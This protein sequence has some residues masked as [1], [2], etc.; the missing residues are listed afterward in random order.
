MLGGYEIERIMP[1]LDFL[2]VMSYDYHGSWDRKTGHNSP[3]YA[4]SDESVDDRRLNV[5]WTVRLYLTLGVPADKL[6]VGIPYYG[7][8]FTLKNMFSLVF[9]FHFI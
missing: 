6:I 4:S 2:N 7:R 1:H 5:D 3:L 8:S 9:F